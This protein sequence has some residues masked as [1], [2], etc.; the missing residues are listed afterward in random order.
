MWALIDAAILAP[1]ALNVQP[2]AFVV[3]EDRALLRE[4][5]ERARAHYLTL[6]FPEP[7]RAKHARS[8]RNRAMS[9]STA[10]LRWS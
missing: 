2:W 9:C 7:T 10:P 3:I 5:G 1:S 6:E 8:S 4:Y